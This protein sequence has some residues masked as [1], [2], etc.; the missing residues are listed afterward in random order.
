VA[1]SRYSC[2]HP[3]A[4]AR[5][6]GSGE[7]VVADTEVDAVLGH[8]GEDVR[9]QRGVGFGHGGREPREVAPF[10]EGITGQAC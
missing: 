2:V 10:A 1:L 4:A 5:S 3:S 8:G 9:G 7:V 6:S